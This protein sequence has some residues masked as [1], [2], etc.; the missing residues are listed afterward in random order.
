MGE[1]VETRSIARGHT[2]EVLLDHT[3][4]KALQGTVETYG[5]SEAL[6]VKHQGVRWT[7][8]VLHEQVQSVASGLIGLGFDKGDR[9]GIWAPNCLEWVV[10]QFAT[11]QIGVVLV[12]INP[13]YRLPELEYALNKVKCRGLVLAPSHKTSDYVAMLTELCPEISDAEINTLNSA[14]LPHLRLVSIIGDSAPPGMLKFDE[15]PEWSTIVTRKKAEQIFSTLSADDPINIQ[16]TSGTTGSPKGAVLSH[17][18][19]LNNG[20]FVGK[21]LALSNTDRVC[22]PVPL[23]HCF[24]MVMGNLA[25]LTHGSTM[26]YPSESFE[27]EE[28]LRSVSE[29]R[30]TA[31]YGV[32]TMFIAMLEHESFKTFDL[33]SLRT[34]IMAGAPCP[35]KV[36]KQVIADMNMSEVT[37][38]YGMTETSP[39]SVQTDRQDPVELRVSTVGRVHPH[40]E[41]KIIDSDGE[42]VPFGVPGEICT[43]GYSVM[44][45]YWGDPDRTAEAIDED[46]WM[47]T[48]DLATMDPSGYVRIVGRLKDL[49][50]RGGEN[51]YPRE[52]EEF[53]YSNPSIQ[54][55]HVFG[56]PNERYGEE[57]CAW[58]RCAPGS[59]DSEESIREFCKGRIA[60]YKIPKIVRFVDDFPCTVTG[61]VKKYEMRNTMCQELGISD[62]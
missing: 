61:K 32:P 50:I 37:I 2:K 16:F 24:G 17:R 29:E 4:G 48:G 27:A 54:E 45:G 8:Q 23:Y 13:A 30:C 21:A 19:I 28:T 55:V 46:G 41:I 35:V 34:G 39:V 57:V 3:I 5:S 51:I 11:A 59:N 49:I 14:R 47:H 1:C 36:M 60:H 7:W 62:L 6:V 44:I 33:T 43:R 53:F 10:A 31:L 22:I 58:I 18:N 52:I 56:I 20:Y 40:L 38:A 25:C 26:V 15:I 9:L 12:N 42:V